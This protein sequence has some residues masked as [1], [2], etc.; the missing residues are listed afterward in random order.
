MASSSLPAWAQA[1]V[2]GSGG[3]PLFS[4]IVG[5]EQPSIAQYQQQFGQAEAGIAGLPAQMQLQGAELQQT[6]GLQ[7]EQIQNQL[8]GNTLEQQNV[9]QQL[10]IAGEQYGLEKQLAGIQQGQ[11]TYNFGVQQKNLQDQG[12]IGGTLNTQGYGRQQGQL[13]EQYQVSS[14]ELAN[15]LAGQG[16]SYQGQQLSAANQTAQLKNTAAGLGISTQQLQAQLASGMTQIGIQGQQSQDQFMQQASQAAAGEAQG[17]GAVLS[18]I[19]ALTGL[20]PQGF[21]GAFPGLYGP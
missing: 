13:A 7:Q 19:G 6:T 16:V 20:G 18:N 9:A 15:Q 1:L 4:A 21:T 8:A 3:S 11:L 12:A 2:G 10:G 5:A 17:Y 14:A